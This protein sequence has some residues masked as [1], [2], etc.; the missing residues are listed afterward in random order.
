[1]GWRFNVPVLALLAIDE[2]DDGKELMAE[3]PWA[4]LFFDGRQHGRVGFDLASGGITE[5]VR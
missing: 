2:Q 5:N 4:L 1:M 3:M